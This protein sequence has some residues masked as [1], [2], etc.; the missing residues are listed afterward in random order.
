MRF[1]TRLLP[2]LFRPPRTEDYP[3]GEARTPST[4]R[5]RIVVDPKACVGCSTCAHVCVSNAIRLDDEAEGVRLTVWHPRCVFCGLCAYYCPT[6]AI[7]VSTEWE[8]SHTNAEK[9]AVADSVV[10]RFRLCIDCGEKVMVP[11]PGVLATKLVGQTAS[12]MARCDACKRSHQANLLLKVH[13]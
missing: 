3:F 9:Y 5:G 11:T 12:E 2:N 1:L 7:E 8:L 10:A 4:Y 13:P 6:D